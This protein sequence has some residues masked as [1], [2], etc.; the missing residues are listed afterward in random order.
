MK[1]NFPIPAGIRKMP[2]QSVTQPAHL[3]KV[4]YSKIQVMVHLFSWPLLNPSL[5]GWPLF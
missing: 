1:S 2:H 3:P 4:D 5:V